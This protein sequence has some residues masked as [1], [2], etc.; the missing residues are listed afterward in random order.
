MLTF[1]FFLIIIVSN[2]IIEF[3]PW[4]QIE[5]I[6]DVITDKDKL[7]S[8]VEEKFHILRYLVVYPAYL[9]SNI[10]KIE[11][12]KTYSFY[13]IF[14][15]FST[16]VIWKRICNYKLANKF[17][18]FI[19]CIIPLSLAF[20]INGRFAF[21]LLGISILIFGILLRRESKNYYYF[22]DIFGLLL[23]N[24]SS[25]TAFVGFIFFVTSNFRDIQKFTRYI[26]FNL[27]PNF[28]LIKKFYLFIP[29]SLIFS[30][31]FLNLVVLINKNITFFGGYKFETLYGLLSH[32]FGMIFIE[33]INNPVYEKCN[34]NFFC[35]I[36]RFLIS[37]NISNV[38]LIIMFIFIVFLTLYFYFY[39]IKKNY[40]DILFK[41]LV[42]ISFIA[43][44]F[45]VTGFLSILVIIPLINFKELLNLTN[46]I[47]GVKD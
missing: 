45:G 23:I 3:T 7:F 18:T 17:E 20:I 24:V 12:T 35:K 10:L 22:V 36:S 2:N 40:L 42:L 19:K 21:S 9:F 11:I 31:A 38:I 34:L 44:F 41:K 37:P 4:I 46:Q 26:F 33:D 5:Y 28:K 15:L 29:I 27:I 13:V 39:I 30:M 25:G 47:L 16:S 6:H 8:E 32:G 1:L 14:V 43:G